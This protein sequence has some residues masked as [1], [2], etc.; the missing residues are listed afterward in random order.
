MDFDTIYNLILT[1]AL[2]VI[3]FFL[4]RSFDALDSRASKSD[5]AEIKEMMKGYDDKYASKSELNEMKKTID[6][7]SDKIDEIKDSSVRSE[8]F[9]RSITRLETKLDNIIDTS[10]RD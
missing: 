7:I 10:R 1:G 8:D 3:S 2:G 9:I 6:K 5:V 4:K